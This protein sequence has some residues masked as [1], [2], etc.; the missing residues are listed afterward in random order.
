MFY[1]FW[2][3]SDAD[4]ALLDLR[5]Y[6]V[7]QRVRTFLLVLNTVDSDH[8][9]GRWPSSLGIPRTIGSKLHAYFYS[10]KSS[11]TS[12]ATLCLLMRQ[13]PRNVGRTMCFAGSCTRGRAHELET[14]TRSG[15]SCFLWLL[16]SACLGSRWRLRRR[17][18][19]SGEESKLLF[20]GERCGCQVSA[21]QFD[22]ILEECGAVFS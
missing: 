21:R 9:K 10:S 13:F 5:M 7:F 15:W 14:S 2:Y 22:R 6:R 8:R 18:S 11:A 1:E 12:I 3:R 17:T 20:G 16:K 19:K 4:D